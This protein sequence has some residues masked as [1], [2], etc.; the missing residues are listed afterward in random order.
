MTDEA[1]DPCG[2]AV[3]SAPVTVEAEYSQPGSDAQT[4]KQWTF[5]EL[6]PRKAKEVVVSEYVPYEATLWR[7]GVWHGQ[8]EDR[9]D[10]GHE[11][12]ILE[13]EEDDE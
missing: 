5:E 11:A 1:Q 3:R 8:S 10:G 9:P 4:T 13:Q 2:S 6:S 7:V 12:G